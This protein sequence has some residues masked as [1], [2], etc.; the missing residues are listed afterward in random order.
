M[1]QRENQELYQCLVCG[2]H[3]RQETLAQQCEEW[4]R[5]H[6]S[7]SLEITKQAIENER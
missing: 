2:F 6:Q 3:Y 1:A 5:E 4:C 7:C